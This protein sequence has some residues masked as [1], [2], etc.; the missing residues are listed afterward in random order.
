[1]N[2]PD[3]AAFVSGWTKTRRR[4]SSQRRIRLAPATLLDRFGTTR[5]PKVSSYLFQGK[6]SI[7]AGVPQQT[8]AAALGLSRIELERQRLC[9]C[10][11]ERER[12]PA[13][14]P[15]AALCLSRS[16]LER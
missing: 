16:E 3:L 4:S 14:S 2:S 7:R 1:M 10:E 9:V 5:L 15:A 6:I 12:A 11:R 8:P 13:C